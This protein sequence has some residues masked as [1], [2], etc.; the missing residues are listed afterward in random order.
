[1]TTNHAEEDQKKT[2]RKKTHRVPDKCICTRPARLAG[3]LFSSEPPLSAS[4]CERC[5]RLES[6]DM[7]TWDKCGS[8]KLRFSPRDSFLDVRFACDA[9]LRSRGFEEIPFNAF[10][11]KKVS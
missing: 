3:K 2:K 8:D 4:A 10:E 5:A 1:M 7:T 6:T 11:H 9:W